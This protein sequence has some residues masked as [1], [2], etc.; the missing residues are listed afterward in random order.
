M[1]H[2][3]S[4]GKY[5]PPGRNG[6]G[7]AI[8]FVIFNEMSGPPMRRAHPEEVTRTDC[9]GTTRKGGTSGEGLNEPNRQRERSL[10]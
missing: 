7:T 4:K 3:D 2:N 5:L 6:L 1:Q 8:A 10:T 9:T